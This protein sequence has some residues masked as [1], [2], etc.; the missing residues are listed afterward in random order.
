LWLQWEC[1]AH[2]RG[3]HGD[4]QAQS[5]PHLACLGRRALLHLTDK[6]KRLVVPVVGEEVGA[7]AGR[8]T[9]GAQTRSQAKQRRT[10][11]SDRKSVLLNICVVN[12]AGN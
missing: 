2:L 5:Q 3:N 11:S 10:S 9:H 1:M 7:Y 4:E 12:V 8:R 6:R